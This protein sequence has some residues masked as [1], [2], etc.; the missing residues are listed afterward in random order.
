MRRL[1]LI[2]LALCQV[3][4]LSA[5]TGKAE[6]DEKYTPPDG[7]ILFSDNDEKESVGIDFKNSVRFNM[8]QLVRGKVSFE[9]ERS[10]HENFSVGL[11]VASSFMSDPVM[12]LSSEAD[13]SFGQDPYLAYNYG[14]FTS[15]YQLNPFIKVKTD[16]WF[17]DNS[18]YTRIGYRYNTF[19]YD[20][21]IDDP[22]YVFDYRLAT[23]EVSII[24][25]VESQKEVG[26][27]VLLNNFY[28]GAGFR[29]FKFKPLE[30]VYF[31]NSYEEVV[32]IESAKEVVSYGL[33][34]YIGYSLGI[35]W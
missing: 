22:A 17:F 6:L 16:S 8:L 27:L 23:S 9:Y 13:Y 29:A 30:R 2:V 26:K 12:T 28:Y 7:S 20:M 18:R 19:N 25:G 31:N 15:G 11:G 1:L 10:L 5:Q 21:N 33:T 4:Y 3:S 24:I 34:L 35:G 32:Q 14:D